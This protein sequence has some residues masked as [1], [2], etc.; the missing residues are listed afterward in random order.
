MTRRRMW[1]RLCF[2]YE[3]SRWLR[4]NL[5]MPNE[6]AHFRERLCSATFDHHTPPFAA[7]ERR[8]SA[9]AHPQYH[10]ALRASRE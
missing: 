4:L 1:K 2:R 9:D 8:D 6:L 10:S 3:F 5:L 7:D